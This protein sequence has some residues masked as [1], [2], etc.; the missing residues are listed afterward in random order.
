MVIII[1][2][3]GIFL[4]FALGFASMALLAARGHRLQCEEGRETQDYSPRRRVNR[5]FPAIPQASGASC[6]LSLVP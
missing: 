3:G 2:I 5:A 1:F 6:H 4:G